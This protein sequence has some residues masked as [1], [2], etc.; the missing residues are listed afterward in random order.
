[1]E[2]IRKLLN[3]FVLELLRDSVIMNA[4]LL[5]GIEFCPG[6][7]EVIFDG[8]LDDAMV[9]EVLDG[10][11]R[12]GIDRIRPDQLLGVQDVAVGRVFGAGAGP[13]GTLQV[14]AVLK[15]RLNSW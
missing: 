11:E 2:G 3:A 5:K 1:M 15:M 14:R 6:L 7:V 10:F 4:D 9:A 13:Q 8:R 12:H